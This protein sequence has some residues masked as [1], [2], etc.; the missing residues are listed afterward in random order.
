ML[1]AAHKFGVIFAKENQITENELFSNST[2]DRPHQLC[3]FLS[4][5]ADLYV[6]PH[7]AE[8]DEAFEAFLQLLGPKIELKGW[9]GYT[10][11]LNTGSTLPPPPPLSLYLL[12]PWLVAQCFSTRPLTGADV[13][14][15]E[16]LPDGTHSVFTQW[17]GLDIMFHVCTT[18]FTSPLTGLPAVCSEGEMHT[19]LHPVRAT[20]ICDT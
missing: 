1:V 19:N 7:A 5:V 20:Y 2:A 6:L 3:F 17:K 15:T 16:S 14:T 10:G 18:Y 12:F 4:L 8:G 9:K 11:G 13:C